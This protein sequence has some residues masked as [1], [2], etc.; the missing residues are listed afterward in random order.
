MKRILFLLMLLPTLTFA[1]IESKKDWLQSE[2]HTLKTNGRYD[3]SALESTLKDKR[4]VAIGESS[5][6]IGDYYEMKSALVQFLHEEMDFEV[7]A[8]EASYGDA[9]LAWRDIEELSVMEL[10]NQTI[11][12]NYNC[13]EI[14]PL[15]KY[16]KSKSKSDKPLI[17]AGFDTQISSSYFQNKA[18]KLIAPYNP[19]YIQKID[20]LLQPYYAMYQAS[21]SGDSTEFNTHRDQLLDNLNGLKEQLKEVKEA[22]IKNGTADEEDHRIMNQ[23]LTGL[24]TACTF[25]YKDRFNEQN[26]FKGM[27]LRDKIMFDNFEQLMVDKYKDKK[28]IIWGHNAHIEK[29]GLVNVSHRWLGHYLSDKYKEEYYALGLFSYKGEVYQHWTKENIP[30]ENKED[31]FLENQLKDSERQAIYVDLNTL[32]KNK[33]N[34]FL[35][36]ECDGREFENGD[37]VRF[38]PVDRFDGLINLFNVKVPTY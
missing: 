35:F 4:I 29:S 13:E 21:W 17:Y 12:G 6:G 38:I 8:M 24:A 30:F 2:S 33:F 10:Q 25:S 36:E 14:T 32:T 18:K 16:I 28:V 9:N 5:H 23:T 31:A 7:L 26:L 11:F 34:H 20:E 22:S 15:F 19:S 3:F 27:E 1:Q 37:V